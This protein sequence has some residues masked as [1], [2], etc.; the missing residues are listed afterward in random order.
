MMEGFVILVLFKEK[1]PMGPWIKG[2]S[3]V[4]K[5]PNSSHLET[6]H[7]ALSIWPS[8]APFVASSPIVSDHLHAPNQGKDHFRRSLSIKAR[9]N[10]T[11]PR[12][13]LL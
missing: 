5:W 9:I 10:K 3:V 13:F 2:C 11:I 1:A 6:L 4:Y 8:V 7:D 12:Q